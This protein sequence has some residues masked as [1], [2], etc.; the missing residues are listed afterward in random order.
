MMV[1]AESIFIIKPYIESGLSK[2]PSKVNTKTRTKGR[3]SNLLAN[4]VTLFSDVCPKRIAL[5]SN[6]SLYTQT[7]DQ[8]EYTWL[9]VNE[10]YFGDISRKFRA[11]STLLQI[12]LSLTGDM[13]II[14]EPLILRDPQQCLEL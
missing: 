10:A 8:I 9:E 4:S 11:I 14:V 13:T 6:I 1:G 5:E 3:N 12:D 2:E 7:N